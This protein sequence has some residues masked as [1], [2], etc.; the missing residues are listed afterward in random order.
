MDSHS[1]SIHLGQTT[2]RR[3]DKTTV[4]PSL[5]HSKSKSNRLAQTIAL[6]SLLTVLLQF[7]PTTLRTSNPASLPRN[8]QLQLI[9]DDPVDFK[10][11]DLWGTATQWDQENVLDKVK[12]WFSSPTQQDWFEEETLEQEF[13]KPKVAHDPL[14]KKLGGKLIGKP[15]PM[16][17]PSDVHLKG[18]SPDD[19]HD[20]HQVADVNVIWGADDEPIQAP[21]AKDKPKDKSDGQ[22]VQEQVAPPVSQG[23]K[24]QGEI[25][26]SLEDDGVPVDFEDEPVDAEVPVESQ[27]SK[28]AD[29]AN[30]KEKPAPKEKSNP[31]EKTTPKEK[32]KAG[33][34][35]QLGP[36][37]YGPPDY[38][39]SPANFALRYS[40]RKS[41]T[42]ANAVIIMLA[43]NRNVEEVERTLLSFESKFNAYVTPPSPPFQKNSEEM[44]R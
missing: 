43:R 41:K 35:K 17:L 28:H 39:E 34:T 22:V 14:V 11:D 16:K 12:G 2:H 5:Q 7:A 32:S 3:R 25:I 8:E 29:M 23:E 19:G 6:G 37:N 27:D 20:S 10:L 36:L 44:R 9:V 24:S 21:I 1:T 13:I 31:K 18:H 33:K 38:T 15:D 40:K 30:E 26:D 42:K 4:T